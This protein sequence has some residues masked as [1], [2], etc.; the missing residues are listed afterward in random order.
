MSSIAHYV[1]NTTPQPFTTYWSDLFA[2]KEIRVIHATDAVQDDFA[3]R[4]L[5]EASTIPPQQ[6]QGGKKLSILAT[7]ANIGFVTQEQ[8]TLNMLHISALTQ[9]QTIPLF[10]G[11]DT[12]TNKITPP[13]YYGPNGL[14]NVDIDWLNVTASVET[15]PGYIAMANLIVQASPEKPITIF[16]TSPL[17]EIAK[18]FEYLL[19]TDPQ[20]TFAQ[21]INALIIRGGCIY[22]D[23]DN[24]YGCN[25]PYN[26]LDRYKNSE[27]NFYSDVAAVQNVTKFCNDHSIPRVLLPLG[28]T[29]VVLWTKAQQKEVEQITNAVT[30]ILAKVLNVVPAPDARRFPADSY[31]LHDLLAAIALIRPDLFNAIKVA[32]SSIGDVGQIFINVNATEEQKLVYLLSLPEDI[33]STFFE[34][35]LPLLKKFTCFLDPSLDICNPGIS[36]DTILK[37]AIP[38]G[39]GSILLLL[40]VACIVHKR[41]THSLSERTKLLAQE[42]KDEK[43]LNTLLIVDANFSEVEK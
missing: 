28:V 13:N 40:V 18:T 21:N 37:I 12:L 2:Q 32:I 42:L 29:Q 11:A 19:K 14:G 20:A 17:T 35:I 33:Q 10:G 30:I 4:V 22:P 23:A 15:T 43:K 26:V 8:A 31:P 5:L 36:L 39:V 41:R 27:I 24:T 1:P 9:N 38:A 3:A 34:S 7:V 25:A 16:I 6:L